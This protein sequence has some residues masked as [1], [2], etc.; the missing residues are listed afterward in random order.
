M[1]GCRGDTYRGSSGW[2][3]FLHVPLLLSSSSQLAGR[4]SAA[5]R[6]SDDYAAGELIRSEGEGADEEEEKEGGGGRRRGTRVVDGRGR[7]RRRRR[8]DRS[9]SVI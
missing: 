1:R 8:S 9:V 3:A 5:I 7:E 4:S 2:R 6:E